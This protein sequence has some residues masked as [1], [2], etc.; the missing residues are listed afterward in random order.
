MK[1]TSQ[2]AVH[3]ARYLL[4]NWL[5]PLGLL[6][7]LTLAMFGDVLFTSQNIVLSGSDNDLTYQFIHW[8]TFGFGELRHGNLALWNPHLFSGAPFFGEFQS[9]LLYPPNA[10]FLFLPLGMA[11][12]WSIALHVFLAGA[13]T[14]AWAAR[15]GLRPAACFLSAVIFMFCGAYFRHIYAGHLPNLCTMVWAPLLF[16]AIDGL[17]GKPSL[18][19]S[20][21]GMFAVAMQVLAGH[22]QYVFYTGVGAA[23]YCAL[24]FFAATEKKKFVFGLAGIVAGGVA[25]SAVQLF[26]GLQESREMVRSAGLPYDIARIFSFPPE[27]FLTLLAPNIFGDMKTVLWWG[28]CYWWEMC[29]FIG[30]SGFALAGVGA[31]W[32]ERRVRR[33]SVVMVVVLLLLALGA[34]TPLFKWLYQWV[35][36]FNLFRGISKFTFLASLFLSMLAGIG[37]DELMKGRRPARL[38]IAGIGV[39]GA[40]LVAAAVWTRPSES[41]QMSE[42]WWY[43]VMRW[44][45]STGETYLTAEAYD[46]AFV[47]RAGR[48][49][50][51]SLLIGGLTLGVVSLLLLFARRYRPSVWLLLAL[52]VS[53][54]SV[55]ARSSLNYFDL[56]QTGNPNVQEYLKSHPGDYRI[57]Q[58]QGFKANAVMSWGAQE[59]WGYDPGVLRRYAQLLAATQ[60]D[61]PDEAAE[62]S[63]SD[64]PLPHEHPLFA[65]L[66]CRFLFVPQDGQ[67]VCYERT[68]YLPHLLLVSRCQVLNSRDKIFS[69]LTN[70]AFNPREEVIL[71][72]AP[73]PKPEPTTDAGSVR[74]VDSTTDSLT[75][76]AEVR[77]PCI[78]LI[79]DTYAKGWRAWALQGS[80]QAHYQV[81]PANYCLRAIPLAAGH[82]L[83]RLEYAPLG[84]E[85][86]KWV[87]MISLGAFLVLA[88]VCAFTRKPSNQKTTSG[89]AARR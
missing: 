81:L 50:S 17:V 67:L 34:R 30:V 83:L 1:E 24:V 58:L 72:T 55:F 73:E 71:E 20:L 45:F 61:N 65:M 35:P 59:I 84:F 79:T 64:I 51:Q 6:A 89:K 32:G 68:N 28:R 5:I 29:L 74:L 38:F 22:P 2:Q 52:A 26:T 69:V 44:C 4:H 25:L 86:G 75:I 11:I 49:A 63:N 16:L 40:L 62:L 10:L 39:L 77:S 48:V 70:A 21:L 8:R 3:K 82:H 19:W 33:F 47:L 15:R 37:L 80:S 31:I 54:L 60:G 27:D 13:F 36:G 43:P 14:Y 23:I 85:V 78:L 41:G 7:A 88:G 57:L 53:E 56:G 12:N 66:R 87:S 76:E 9:A 18:G 46:A 42:N